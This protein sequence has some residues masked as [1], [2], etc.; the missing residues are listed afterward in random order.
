[1]HHS[2]VV[3]QKGAREVEAAEGWQ[4]EARSSAGSVLGQ[5]KSP[6]L[7]VQTQVPLGPRHIVL[8]LSVTWE[9]MAVLPGSPPTG[10]EELQG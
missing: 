9:T 7:G 2:K 1:M 10:V 8:L 3:Q 4:C 5:G 6:A